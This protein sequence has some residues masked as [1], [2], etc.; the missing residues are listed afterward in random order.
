MSAS[1][2]LWGNHEGARVA[3]VAQLARYFDGG[4]SVGKV[5]HEAAGIRRELRWNCEVAGAIDVTP[6]RVRRL[7]RR[8]DA[9]GKIPDPIKPIVENLPSFDVEER[10]CGY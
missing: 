7:E 9:L 1:N 2:K 4:K 8:G 10:T 5:A 3:N 6:L